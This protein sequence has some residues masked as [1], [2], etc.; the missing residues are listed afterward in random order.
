MVIKNLSIEASYKRPNI[1]FTALHPGTVNTS[2]SKPFQTFIKGKTIFTPKRSAEYLINVL[3]KLT[4]EDSG[5]LFS[6]DGSQIP[7]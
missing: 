3:E 2:L 7:F 1:I 6:W 4:N 5:K